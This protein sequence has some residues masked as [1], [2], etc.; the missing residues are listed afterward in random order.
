MDLNILSQKDDKWRVFAFKLTKDKMLSDD[1]VN[2]MYLKL[3]KVEKEINDFYVYA[4]IRNLYFDFLRL[5]NKTVSLELLSE[6]TIDV[7]FE[8]DDTEKHIIE[9]VYWVARDYMLLMSDKK[10]LRQI[11]K[12]LNTNYG[13]IYRT[14]K[15]EKDKWEELKK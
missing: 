7:P 11:G 13:F 12:E 2:D 8:V 14:V 10:S 9:N 15:E 4:T 5:D 6:R 3:H 1:L